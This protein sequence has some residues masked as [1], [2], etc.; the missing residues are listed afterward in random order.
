VGD[1]S[2]LYGINHGFLWQNGVMT[3]LGILS[4]G[5]WS[6]AYGINNNGQ[7][8][9]SGDDASGYSH[10]VLWQNGKITNLGTLPGGS[11]SSASGINDNGQI[12]GSS[13]NSSG[14]WWVRKY[15]FRNQ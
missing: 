7:I 12:V 8:V 5:S 6:S 15:G 3:D 10:A 11:W 9:G 1:C 2:F 4:G 14:N 13:G